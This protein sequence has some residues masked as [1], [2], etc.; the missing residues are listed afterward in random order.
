MAQKKT[1]TDE[2]LFAQFED[3]PSASGATSTSNATAIT[4]DL[5][6]SEDDPL[7]E[8]SALAAARP[9]SR[10]TTPR[11]SSSTTS[12]TRRIETPAG[13]E[14]PSVRTSEEKQL[15]AGDGSIARKSTESIRN[16][17]DVQSTPE[18]AKDVSSTPAS[19]SGGWWGSVYSAASA[20][21]KQAEAAVNEIRS[22]EEAQ[23]W[24]EQVRGNV[25][26]VKAYGEF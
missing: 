23:K 26:K 12:G 14:P 16:H 3:I 24:A 25:E 15:R 22:N 5:A 10:P 18:Q 13:S 9:T 19:Q 7:A 4:S 17:H 21:V 2:E 11:V 20:A 8:L 6:A 1:L